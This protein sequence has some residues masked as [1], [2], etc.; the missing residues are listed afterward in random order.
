MKRSAC[1]LLLIGALLALNF[2][3]ADA[4]KRIHVG[5]R[6]HDFVLETLQGQRVQLRTSL[7]EKATLVVFWATWSPRSAEALADFQTLY[8][9]Y[10]PNA[11]QVIAVNVE[12][13]DWNPAEIHKL[14]ETIETVGATYPVV[15]DKD[16]SIFNEYGVIAVPSS[17]LVDAA[18]AVVELLPGYS[19]MTRFDFRERVLEALGV[20]V[21]KAKEG[22]TTSVEYVPKGKAAR[23][24]QM[25]KML[26]RKKMPTKAIRAFEKAIAEDPDYVEAY[27]NLFQALTSAGRTQEAER[28]Q[29][30]IAS[31][32]G[33]I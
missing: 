11:L 20:L 5:E 21:P 2:Q 23:Y 8:D 31:I 32:E 3:T 28:I 14:A 26:L 9:E 33:T 29:A 24:C 22:P 30:K 16:L 17:V 27:Q 25:G 1:S 6:A 15:V 19:N 10:G 4:F 12:H 7:G 13:Q 18:G